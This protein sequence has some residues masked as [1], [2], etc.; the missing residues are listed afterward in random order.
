MKKLKF[1]V[2]IFSFL[3]SI[4]FCGDEQ[5]K[6]FIANEENLT[7]FE[8]LEDNKAIEKRFGVKFK[9]YCD[10]IKDGDCDHHTIHACLELNGYYMIFAS[11][12]QSDFKDIEALCI[13]LANPKMLCKKSAIRD[14][15][16]TFL[17]K[18]NKEVIEI[19]GEATS[20]YSENKESTYLFTSPR[21]LSDNYQN[22]ITLWHHIEFYFKNDKAIS[23]C[24]S[25]NLE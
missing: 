16:T 6:R 24:V 10:P 15:K 11:Y 21:N 5:I 17:G 22:Q 14:I 20:K 12:L 9:R 19:V 2:A 7:G 1:L 8:F 3:Y 13:Q 4:A 18:T 25:K 23:Y